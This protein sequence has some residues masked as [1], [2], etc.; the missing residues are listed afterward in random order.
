M[1]QV[2]ANDTIT[3]ALFNPSPWLMFNFD[4]RNMLSVLVNVELYWICR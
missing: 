1:F 2:E 3:E 4:G